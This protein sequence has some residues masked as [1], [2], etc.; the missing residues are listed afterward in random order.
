MAFHAEAR[1][2]ATT[3]LHRMFDALGTQRHAARL[4]NVTQRHI[5]RWRSGDRRL[6]H[7]VAIV[8]RLLVAGAIT[9]DQIEN[10]VASAPVQTNGGAKP[11]PLAPLEEA[12]QERSLR[13][14]VKTPAP[15]QSAPTR[16]PAAALAILALG[17]GRCHW[18]IGDPQTATFS[19][20]NSP[21][22]PQQP[23]CARHRAQARET[24]RS[25]HDR[26]QKRGSVP[27]PT[28][29]LAPALLNNLN[30]ACVWPALGNK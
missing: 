2:L 15:E 29:N 27:D 10:V 13:P 25:R 18:P 24:P 17:S 7:A 12:S 20:C 3:E 22:I 9:L 11:E 26:C 16:A 19:F 8:I 30:G 1:D 6:P 14:H 23:Y 21:A 28:V 5:R 4:F